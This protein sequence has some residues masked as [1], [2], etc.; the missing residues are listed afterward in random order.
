MT[1][2]APVPAGDAGSIEAPW[3]MTEA[4]PVPTGDVLLAV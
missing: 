1:E 2:A 4:A 3:V